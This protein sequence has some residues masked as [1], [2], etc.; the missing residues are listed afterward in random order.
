MITS[1]L[2]IKKTWAYNILTDIEKKQLDNDHNDDIHVY[3]DLGP[4]MPF[5]WHGRVYG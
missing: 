3:E 5:M 4:Y 2:W 1:M